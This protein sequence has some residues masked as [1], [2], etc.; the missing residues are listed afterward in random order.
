MPRRRGIT[1]PVAGLASRQG[2]VHPVV[3]AACFSALAQKTGG[4]TMFA[5]TGEVAKP[6]SPGYIVGGEP[7][8]AGRRV[9]TEY[10]PAD[11]NAS[12]DRVLHH[13]QRIAAGTDASHA[14]V[15]YWRDPEVHNSP[16]EVDSSAIFHDRR[17]ATSEGKAR[18]EKSV[19]DLGKMTDI[20]FR[21]S[22]R[23]SA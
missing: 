11:Q 2:E 19:W 15:G 10:E 8:R 13:R 16:Y 3:S 18:G 20:R 22:G 14:A 1:D 7:D 21:K 23:K 5:K 4:A 9:P 17:T 6:H 12:L